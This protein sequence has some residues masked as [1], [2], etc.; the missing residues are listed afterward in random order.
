VEAVF[1]VIQYEEPSSGDM[2]VERGM[3]FVQQSDDLPLSRIGVTG[4]ESIATESEAALFSALVKLVHK[5]NPDMLVGFDCFC[6]LRK[7]CFL[8]DLKILFQV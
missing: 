8:T 1:F 5:W 6:S 3:L 7:C 4:I 2:L